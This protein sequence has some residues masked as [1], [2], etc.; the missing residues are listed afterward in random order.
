MTNR[1]FEFDFKFRALLDPR[2]HKYMCMRSHNMKKVITAYV[3][4]ATLCRYDRFHNLRSG[5]L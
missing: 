2:V 1:F 4:F 3:Q 5:K